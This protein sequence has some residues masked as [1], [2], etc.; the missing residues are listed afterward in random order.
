MHYSF[1]LV[2]NGSFFAYIATTQLLKNLLL[3]YSGQPNY[4]N[5]YFWTQKRPNEKFPY[6]VSLF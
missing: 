1:L 6:S 2:F 5:L 3:A 4:E